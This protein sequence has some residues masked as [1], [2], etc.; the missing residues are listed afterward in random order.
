[1][2][3]VRQVCLALVVLVCAPGW[4]QTAG[5]AA[6]Q[7]VFNL[8]KFEQLIGKE[9][10]TLTRAADEVILNSDFQFTDRGTPVPLVT[11]LTM[12]KDLT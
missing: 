5:T 12:E 8:H 10:Y 6:E 7:G 9:T 4:A 1:M 11:T 2:K 3:A